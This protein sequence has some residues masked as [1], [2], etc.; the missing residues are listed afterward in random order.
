[1]IIG[2]LGDCHL[3]KRLYEANPAWKGIV[4]AEA[5]RC[6]KWAMNYLYENSTILVQAADLFDGYSVSDAALHEVITGIM[7]TPDWPKYILGGNHDSTKVY[8]RLCSLDILDLLPNTFVT[9]TFVP[10]RRKHD[11]VT[12]LFIPHMKSQREFDDALD[13][14]SGNDIVVCHASYGD[15]QNIK[16]PNDLYVTKERMS[17][18]AD[19]NGAVFIGHEHTPKQ[20]M[21]NVWQ[22]GSLMPY[23]FAEGGQ[24]F[25]YLYNTAT[26][27]M[28][29]VP[30][31]HLKFSQR[32]WKWTSAADMSTKLMHDIGLHHKDHALKYTITEIPAAELKA[33]KL[34]AKSIESNADSIV[35]FDLNGD[36]EPELAEITH[37]ELTF[38]VLTEFHFYGQE[39]KLSLP[40]F[41]R[42]AA[43][44]E[45][46]DN[47]EAA[48]Q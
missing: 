11:N 26:Q 19:C 20:L 1:M 6:F 38:N 28:E 31:P 25:I 42:M 9:N 47:G 13:A 5:N 7:N 27:E 22:V 24:H 32:T 21:A 43:R 36:Y 4:W 15:M 41:R 33:A 45:E 34:I 3:D 40:Q 2:V 23:S 18:V 10:K 30:V 17:R 37:H 35:R 14:A 39:R 44:L 12:M 46:V 16:G 29:Q 8:D 48:V